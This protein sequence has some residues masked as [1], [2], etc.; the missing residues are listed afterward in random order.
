MTLTH[1]IPVG[2]EQFPDAISCKWS[3]TITVE[4][5]PCWVADGFNL[6]P[7]RLQRILEDAFQSELGYAYSHEVV[8]T[9]DVQQVPA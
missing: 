8:V 6:T 3:A 7:E 9:A 4:V 5:A 2:D 1:E